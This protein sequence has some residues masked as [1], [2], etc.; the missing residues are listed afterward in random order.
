[1]LWHISGNRDESVFL[2]A[3]SLILDRDNARRHVSFGYGIHR[4]IG[5]RLAELQVSVLL[6]E[7]SK[8]RMRVNVLEEPVRVASCLINGYKK[9]MVELVNY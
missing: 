9:M 4:C 8:R 5:A 2:N 1:M 7:M 6:E 3:E